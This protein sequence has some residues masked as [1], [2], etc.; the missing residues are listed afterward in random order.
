MGGEAQL[1]LA[2]IGRQ[3]HM[4]RLGDKGAADLAAFL[5]A[6]RDVLQIGIGRGEPPGRGRGQRIGGVDPRVVAVDLVGERVGIGR[7]ELGQLAPFEHPAGHRMQRQQLF[8]D[9]GVGAVGAGLA[10]AAARQVE[11]VEQN[12]AQLLGRADVEVVADILVDRGL[13]LG[14]AAGEIG[15][16]VGERGAVDLDPGLLHRRDR[17]HQ[18]P[19]DV[20]VE[21]GHVVGDEPRLE[22]R[23]QPQ[24]RVGALG[25]EVARRR[26]LDLGE[27]NEVLAGADQVLERASNRGRRPARPAPRWRGRTGRHRAHTTS[28]SCSRKARAG[29]RG[30]AAAAPR[31]SCRGR[32]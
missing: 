27:G 32:S 16:E 29:C 19:L 4:P 23:V 22:V 17:R 14:D 6:D 3:Q 21:R 31:P 5:G 18:R 24:R 7:F 1:D 15:R 10:L 13:D 2:V 11:L 20:L 28:A 12:L 26:R 9:R 8:E 30:A 25:G